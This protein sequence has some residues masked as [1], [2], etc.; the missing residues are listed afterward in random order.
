MSLQDLLESDL[1]ISITISIKDLKEFTDYLIQNVREQ[2]EES[3]LAKKRES[4]IKP[5]EACK[6]LQVDRSTLWRWAKTGYLIPAEVGGKRLY[7]QS[8]IDAILNR[9]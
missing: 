2:I 6:Q 3:I 5:T 9:Q 8:D 1:N 7:R 4:Y